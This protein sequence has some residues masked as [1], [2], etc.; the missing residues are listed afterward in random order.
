MQEQYDPKS[1]Y[2]RLVLELSA[3]K[4]HSFNNHRA[5]TTC[6]IN[7]QSHLLLEKKAPEKQ[8]KPLEYQGFSGMELRG[9]EPLTSSLPAKHSP[10]EL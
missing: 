7:V 10:A 9:F 3:L 5:K 4:K 8:E 2:Y 1:H 6:A